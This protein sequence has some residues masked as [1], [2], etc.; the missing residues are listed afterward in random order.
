MWKVKTVALFFP[1]QRSLLQIAFLLLK[2]N[3]LQP[4][5]QLFENRRPFWILNA[6][7][8]LSKRNSSS[9]KFVLLLSKRDHRKSQYWLRYE[10]N[11]SLAA[12]FSVDAI[13]KRFRVMLWLGY[14]TLWHRH[15]AIYRLTFQL[16]PIL[17]G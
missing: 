3:S 7:L 1:S 11:Q 17:P 9:I 2:K 10:K 15:R 13:L 16:L 4:E 8:N 6:I 5:L 14:V 12:I